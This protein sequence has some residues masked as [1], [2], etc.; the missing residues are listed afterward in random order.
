M[1]SRNITKAAY[2]SHI[3]RLR[4]RRLLLVAGLLLLTARFAERSWTYSYAQSVSTERHAIDVPQQ[5][6]LQQKLQPTSPTELVDDLGSGTPETTDAMLDDPDN[7]ITRSGE[8]SD[9]AN[10]SGQITIVTSHHRTPILLAT[11]LGQH[12]A[13]VKLQSSSEAPTGKTNT[14]ILNGILDK[15]HRSPYVPSDQRLTTQVETSL[16]DYGVLPEETTLRLKRIMNAAAQSLGKAITKP[17]QSMPS[18]PKSRIARPKFME[19]LPEYDKLNYDK[20]KLANRLA[21]EIAT[22]PNG[23]VLVNP[24]ANKKYIRFLLNGSIHTIEPGSSLRVAVGDTPTIRFHRGS[25]FGNIR[26]ELALKT[27]VFRI[28]NEGWELL[29]IGDDSPN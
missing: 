15:S 8:H 13:T 7:E 4:L 27:Y 3:G 21:S 2:E 6:P 11:R 22:E 18:R 14:R 25:S 17:N 23:T 1:S 16:P 12:S 10:Q 24:R 5:E 19:P 26:K 9:E 29:E 28:S 20:D